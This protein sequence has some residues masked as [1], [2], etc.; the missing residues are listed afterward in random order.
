MC[1]LTFGWGGATSL[2][3]TVGG[4][5]SL[6][7]TDFCKLK[8][9]SFEAVIWGLVGQFQRLSSSNSQSGS[10]IAAEAGR[11]LPVH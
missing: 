6:L 2:A 1:L 5:A 9:E 11:C 8:L 3:S 7:P 4:D 10:R